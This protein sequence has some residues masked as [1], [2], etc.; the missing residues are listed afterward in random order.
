MNGSNA[1]GSS[2]IYELSDGVSEWEN[3]MDNQAFVYFSYPLFP[4][5]FIPT[6]LENTLILISV[7]KFRH[8]RSNMHILI[9]KLA[10]PDLPIGVCRLYCFKLSVVLIG[11]L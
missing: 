4:V 8:L 9:G 11:N 5:I 1:D 2:G 3:C 6:L 10:V 7:I